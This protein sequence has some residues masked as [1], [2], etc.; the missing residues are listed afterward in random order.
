MAGAA[1]LQKKEHVEKI[2]SKIINAVEKPV[3][4]KMRAGISGKDCYRFKEIAK[5]AE[6][7]GISMIALHPRT[8]KQGY[9]GK[10]D[11]NLIKELKNIVNIPVIGNGDIDSPEAAS[12][13]I[14]ETGCDYVMVG[15]AARG[16]PF[17][18][19]QIDDYV[20]KGSYKQVNINERIKSFRTYLEYSKKFKVKISDIKVHAMSYTK[21]IEGSAELRRKLAVS[22]TI[23]E[24]EAIIE[25]ISV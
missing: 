9:S 14:E 5:I 23:K 3:T 8:V 17:I 10:A 13:M 7:A 21:G 2:F 11:W 24:I 25:K 19:R 22:K 1:L 18:F 15:R 16:N 6:D 20:K 4:L 12:R